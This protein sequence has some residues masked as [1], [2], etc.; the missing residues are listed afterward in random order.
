MRNKAKLD[1]LTKIGRGDSAE[2]YFDNGEPV[3][4][5][6]GELMS[7]DNSK[8]SRSDLYATGSNFKSK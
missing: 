3:V 4:P 2:L 1:L 8:M 6:N 7:P 5:E